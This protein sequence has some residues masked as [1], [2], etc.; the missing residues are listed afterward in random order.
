MSLPSC[1]E[2][3]ETT[4]SSARPACVTPFWILFEFCFFFTLCTSPNWSDIYLSRIEKTS[5]PLSWGVSCRGL[6][7]WESVFHLSLHSSVSMS[8]LQTKGKGSLA[9][10]VQC[11]KLVDPT[12]TL[13]DRLLLGALP[14]QII[15]KSFGIN[16]PFS[17]IANQLGG[18]EFAQVGRQFRLWSSSFLPC[19]DRCLFCTRVI[20][21]LVSWT[22]HWWLAQESLQGLITNR[23]VSKTAKQLAYHQLS[24]PELKWAMGKT[25]KLIL[26]D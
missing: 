25:T 20:S 6:F 16:L 26:L 22:L 10:A 14:N 15:Y 5:K 19:T 12:K 13:T 1:M 7:T 4:I 23:N 11:L 17:V 24:L 9:T 2:I 21:K 18:L 8:P 3:P